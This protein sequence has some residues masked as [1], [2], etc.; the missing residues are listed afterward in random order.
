MDPA[1][2]KAKDSFAAL[3]RGD[4]EGYAACFTPDAVQVGPVGGETRGRDALRGFVQGLPALLGP[5][6][7]TEEGIYPRGLEVA[8]AWT[9]R[10]HPGGRPLAFRG[11]SH[12]TH[13]PSGH[14]QFLRIHWD[15]GALQEGAPAP[16]PPGLA[17]AWVRAMSGGRP[18]DLGAIL[19]P[20][21]TLEGMLS[22]GS[23][24]GASV[25]A[26]HLSHVLRRAGTPTFHLEDAFGDP[27]HLALRWVAVNAVKTFRGVV[28][29]EAQGGGGI[30]R[31]QLFWD[32]TQ[33]Q[34]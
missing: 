2:L 26:H 11:I 3:S 21:V 19:A 28:L 22:A 29:L 6:A 8:M 27:G 20:E 15:P 34:G 18:G 16:A 12:W 30:S 10:A 32:P 25:V 23:L 24:Q 9:C 14:I 4:A 7:F 1:L 33:V 17:S 13:A 5:I 31:I